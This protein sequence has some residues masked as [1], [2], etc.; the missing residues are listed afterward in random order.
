MVVVGRSVGVMS[1]AQCV[2]ATQHLANVEMCGPM[3]A[4]AASKLWEATQSMAKVVAESPLPAPSSSAAMPSMANGVNEPQFAAPNPPL[5]PSEKRQQPPKNKRYFYAVAIGKVPGVYD[6]WQDTWR[7]V[8]DVRPNLYAKF[9]TKREAQ[10]FVDNKAN[11]TKSPDHKDNFA[12]PPPSRDDYVNDST[13]ADS[14][15]NADKKCR[16]CC[17]WWG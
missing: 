4:Y 7:Q 12:K 13:A 11:F 10:A 1:E 17:N 9:E 2:L 3:S 14:T 15:R 8:R 16:D 5:K 6:T